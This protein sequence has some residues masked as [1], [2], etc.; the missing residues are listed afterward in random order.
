VAHIDKHGAKYWGAA[1]LH[2][3]VL[4][5]L[6][7]A[8]NNRTIALKYIAYGISLASLLLL[9]WHDRRKIKNKLSQPLFIWLLV[10]LGINAIAFLQVDSALQIV[11]A[12]EY[13]KGLL[14]A[15]LFATIIV[16]AITDMRKLG[17]AIWALGLASVSISISYLWEFRNLS[18][19]TILVNAA[20]TFRDFSVRFIFYLPFLVYLFSRSTSWLK[21]LWATLIFL[22]LIFITFSGFRGGWL[23]LVVMIALWVYYSPRKRK[24]IG[25]TSICVLGA[26]V[27]WGAT[28][29]EY[30]ASKLQQTDTSLR[31]DGTWRPTIVMIKNNPLAG[32]GFCDTAFRAENARLVDR[33]PEWALGKELM[34]PHSIYLESAFAAGIPAMLILVCLFWV[35]L[36]DIVHVIDVTTDGVLRGYSV[37][38]LCMFMSYFVVL[39]IFEPLQWEQLGIVVGL[40]LSLTNILRER[41]LVPKPGKSVA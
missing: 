33:H 27:G 13:R 22:Q 28:S 18:V 41:D 6:F 35:I 26:I 10:F 19:D 20:P 30:V 38:V 5:L 34:D 29:S 39:G 16:V 23:G 15:G 7:S 4:L 37:A 32:H 24:V 14:Q 11:C 12:E 36:R 40:A 8:Y 1:L 31:W 2:L 21:L 25:L 3:G 17:H 9:A